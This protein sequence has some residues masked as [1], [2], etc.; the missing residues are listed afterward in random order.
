MSYALC[1]QKL[2]DKTSYE[3][4]GALWAAELMLYKQNSENFYTWIFSWFFW[5]NVRFYES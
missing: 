5:M 2:W 4:C 3:S 1:L